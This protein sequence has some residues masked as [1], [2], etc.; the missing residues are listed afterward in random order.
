M[1]RYELLIPV[2]LVYFLMIG[3]LIVRFKMTPWLRSKE[4]KEVSKESRN[5]WD[6][7]GEAHGNEEFD[8]LN[9]RALDLYNKHK[10]FPNIHNICADLTR[11]I[12][13]TRLRENIKLTKKD[14]K[15]V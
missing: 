10:Q 13:A 7:T 4:E 15:T 2:A 6:D 8:K 3:G 1:A 14:L 9:D 11:N 5:I 12:E